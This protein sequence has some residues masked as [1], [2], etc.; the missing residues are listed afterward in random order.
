MMDGAGSPL[1]EAT[2]VAPDLAPIAALC[3]G[4]VKY[5]EDGGRRYVYMEGLRFL[6]R[7]QETQM[8]ALLCVNYP[9]SSYPTKLYLPV[10]L[11]LNLNW[12]ENAYI[13]AR[14]WFSWSWK[15]VRPNQTPIEILAGHLE[16]FK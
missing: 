5:T 13:L 6:V 9:N 8:D 10:N 3:S 1:A 11:G 7:G 15:D 4:R 12:N 2:A 14:P 16:A